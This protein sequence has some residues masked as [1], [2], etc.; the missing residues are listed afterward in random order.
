EQRLGKKEPAAERLTKII[1]DGQTSA[2]IRYPAQL[3]LAQILAEERRAAK[4]AG[5]AARERAPDARI[6][7]LGVPGGIENDLHVYLTW[8][9][10]RTDV[11]LWVL[12]PSGKKIFYEYKVGPDGEA[13]HDDVTTGYGPESFTARRA[14][15]GEYVVQVNY[16]G[17]GRGAFPEARGEVVIV[18][19]E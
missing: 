1:G 19:D 2:Q 14:T 5:D 18:T 12:T 9:T 17:G 10:D 16:F 11:D 15:P 3:R 7:E 4:S 13:L 8:D 6:D